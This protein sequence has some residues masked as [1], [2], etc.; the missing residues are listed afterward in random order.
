MLPYFAFTLFVSATL[1]FFVQPLIGKMVLPKL[2][3]TPAVWNTCMVFFQAVLLVGYAY[4]HTLNTW[5]SQ[6]QQFIAHLV[7]LAL[8]FVVLPFTLG[9]WTP[10]TESNPVFS[11]LWLLLGLVGL[12]FFVVSTSAPLLQRWFGLTGHPAAKDPYF[13]YG[14]S[15]LGSMIGLLAYPLV[16]EPLLDVPGQATFWAAGYGLFALLVAGCVFL[17]WKPAP[18]N[19][20][21]EAPPAEAPAAPTPPVKAETAITAKRGPARRVALAHAGAAPSLPVAIE[22]RLENVTWLRRLRW[23]GLAAAPSSLMLGLTTYLTTDIAAIP[24]FWVIP[25]ALYLLTFILVFARWPVV[26]TDVPHTIILYLQP[27]VLLMLV[28]ISCAYINLPFY[29]WSIFG[30]HILSFF[31]TTL[32]CHGELAKDRPAAEHLTEFYLWMSVGGVAGGVFNTLVAPLFFKWGVLEYWLAMILA[33]ICRPSMVTD[34]TLFPGDTNPRKRTIVGF[35]LD[36]ILPVAVGA[37]AYGLLVYGMAHAEHYSRRTYLLAAPT[38]LV[39]TLAMR[40]LRLGL[41]TALLLGVVWYYDLRFERYVFQE[42]GFFGFVK[43][44]QESG[45]IPVL[46]EDGSFKNVA[47]KY[48]VL[49][50]GGIDHGRQH[51]DPSRRRLPI[52]Y[53][54]PTGGIGQVFQHLDWPDARLPASLVGQGMLPGP[55]PTGILCDLHSEP[56]FAVIGLGTGTLAGRA[57]PW[58][59]MH[60]Y[61]IDPL[62]RS[63]S[64]PP[65]GRKPLFTY[66]QDAIDR[67]ADLDIFM[68]DGRLMLQRDWIDKRNPNAAPK[69]KDNFYHVIVLDAFSSD[70][71]PVHILTADA[72][73]EYLTK[74]A[75]GGVLIFNTTNRYV[76]LHGV[77]A[78]IADHHDLIA[79]QFGDGPENVPDKFGSDWVVLQ[80]RNLPEGKPYTGL[81]PL[82]NLL[83][84]QRWRQP[85]RDPSPVWTD[86]YSNL[87]RVI[88]W[89]QQSDE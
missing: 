78:N 73:G 11:L 72:V 13:L 86:A 3:G 42:R 88:Y 83:D 21:A 19:A 50:H 67:E 61:E 77:L 59:T 79:L 56:P 63:L 41:A 89:R 10:P 44:R 17:V 30:F 32:M 45:E 68:G 6:R 55:L 70:A 60:I 26:W 15:N 81:R 48:N 27:C 14:A 29:P 1:L 75:E 34:F 57:K 52:S 58:Q 22:E 38:I 51:L 37:A 76:D 80:R 35:V 69:K 53:F 36:A 66:V 87:L 84:M 28:L 24:F 47:T 8:P 12:P 25:L 7:M 71:I 20:L 43:V 4:T 62:V 74:L 85:P 2:G 65:S 31:V 33:C 16:L 82:P 46:Q 5:R 64:L 9:S 39:L 49:I 54:H 40:P 23:I 18:A